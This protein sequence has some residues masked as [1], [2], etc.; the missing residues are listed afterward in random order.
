MFS[1][2]FW[3]TIY[4]VKLFLLFTNVEPLFAGESSGSQWFFD[5]TNHLHPWGDSTHTNE[6]WNL[7]GCAWRLRQGGVWKNVHLDRGQNQPS[8][9]QTQVEPQ[10]P[11]HIH[12]CTGYLWLWELWQEQLWTAVYQLRQWEPTAVLCEA[13]LQAGTG[14]HND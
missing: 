9:L 2:A 6:H 14:Q 8:H 5:N 11:A 1:L 13:H 4:M 7:H 12:R 10:T 3:H